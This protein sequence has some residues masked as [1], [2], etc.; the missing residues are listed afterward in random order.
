MTNNQ[1]YDIIALSLKEANKNMEFKEIEFNSQGIRTVIIDNQQWFCVKDVC[2]V[3]GV[4]NYRHIIA[5]LMN[6][7]K[8]V[9][10]VRDVYLIPVKRGAPT[11]TMTNEPGLY[12]IIFS[13]EPKNVRGKKP[14][15]IEDRIKKVE[16]FKTWVYHDVLPSIRKYGQY[17]DKDNKFNDVC[18]IKFD[19]AYCYKLMRDIIRA[20]Q[21]NSSNADIVWRNMYIGFSQQLG[22]NI[23]KKA[24][25]E[26]KTKIE[27]ISDNGLME[28]FCKFIQF[29]ERGD[30]ENCGAK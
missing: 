16:E 5:K 8:K 9:I 20:R 19:R 10:N 7:E 24:V 21:M 28:E 25:A 22:Y 12:R 11:I 17:I 2:G 18:P 6:D 29:K 23:N 30:E 4:V 14:E 1:L 27:W 13:L 26:H 3:F 15:E